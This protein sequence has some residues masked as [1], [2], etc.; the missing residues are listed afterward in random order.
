MSPREALD[1]A[2][3]LQEREAK[4]GTQR[5]ERAEAAHIFIQSY[6]LATV[7]HELGA[8][9]ALMSDNAAVN[10]PGL[11]DQANRAL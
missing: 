11:F 5:P 4:A 6:A 8:I 1:R 10:G 2:L 9:R 3:A 7:A